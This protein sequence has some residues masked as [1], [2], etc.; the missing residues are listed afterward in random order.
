MTNP[1]G[2]VNGTDSQLAFAVFVYD[3]GT[4]GNVAVE[5]TKYWLQLRFQ[6][7]HDYRIPYMLKRT[8][9][10]TGGR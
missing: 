10:A 3:A 1:S 6:L 7:H 9:F 8:N 4:A 5:I 2:N